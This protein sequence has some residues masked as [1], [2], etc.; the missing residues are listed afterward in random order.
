MTEQSLE[1]K[2]EEPPVPI[3][4][5]LGFFAALAVLVVAL[6]VGFLVWL[7]SVT[8][9]LGTAFVIGVAVFCMSVLGKVAIFGDDG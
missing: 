7:V 5:M 3:K 2:R 8:F 9:G 1:D 4:Y 6:I